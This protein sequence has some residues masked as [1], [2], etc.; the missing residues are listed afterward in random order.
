MPLMIARAIARGSS[1]RTP[2]LKL[3]GGLFLKG[4]L[5]LARG[6]ELMDELYRHRSFTDCS[7]DALDRTLPHIAGGKNARHCCLQKKW[8]SLQWPGA[9]L[10]G[11]LSRLHEP[12]AIE[13]DPGR[14]PFRVRHRTDKD[15]HGR[16]RELLGLTGFTISQ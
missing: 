12:V 7:R 10:R 3:R 5:F 13:I 14:Q 1:R 9:G 11:L 15:E 2:R 4:H 16:T 8:L 6:Q